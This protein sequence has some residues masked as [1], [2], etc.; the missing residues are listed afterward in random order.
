MEMLAIIGIFILCIFILFVIICVALAATDCIWEGIVTLACLAVAAVAI[1][2]RVA[3]RIRR[4]VSKIL[5]R[6]TK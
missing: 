5:K 3:D 1:I 6:K 4:A 2:V